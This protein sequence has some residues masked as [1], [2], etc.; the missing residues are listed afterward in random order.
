MPGRPAASLN[1]LPLRGGSG[2]WMPES[3]GAEVA[4]LFRNAACGLGEMADSHDAGGD[5]TGTY[6]ILPHLLP[7]LQ[8]RC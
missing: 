1:M 3:V 4:G 6:A 7:E 2:G 8:A 5:V